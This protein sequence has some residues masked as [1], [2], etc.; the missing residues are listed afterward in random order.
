[1]ANQE[2]FTIV[3]D[4]PAPEAVLV[5]YTTADGTALKYVD[6]V[7]RSGTLTFAAGQTTQTVEVPVLASTTGVTDKAFTLTLSN[8]RPAG[9]A[10]LSA[11][12]ATATCEIS[13]PPTYAAVPFPGY[14]CSLLG[15]SI[16]YMCHHWNPAQRV[17]TDVPEVLRYAFYATGVT[18]WFTYANA[19][20]NQCLELEPALQ[21]NTNPGVNATAPNN[22][23]NF[24]IYSSQIAQWTLADFDPLAAEDPGPLLAHNIGPIVNAQN[25]ISAFDMVMMMGG[26]NDLSGGLPWQGILLNIQ[27]CAYTFAK[28]GKWVF[29]FPITPRSADLLQA[30]NGVG[31]Y[32]QAEVVQIIQNQLSINAG[33]KSWIANDAPPNIFFVDCYEDLVGPTATLIP[34]T[35]T[36]PAGLL[37]P[38]SGIATGSLI[39]SAPGNYRSDAPDSLFNFDGLHPAPPGAYIMGRDLAATM[40]AAGVPVPAGQP[41]TLGPLTI[42]PN[43]MLNPTFA[44]STAPRVIGQPLKL[45]RAIGL[46]API[47]WVSPGFPPGYQG[48]GVDL[49]ANQGHGYTHGAVPDYW[50][51][52]RESNSDGESFSNFNDYTFS[53]FSSP[54]PDAPAGTVPPGYLSDSTWADGAVTTSVVEVD[55]VPGWQ[56]AVNIPA[57]LT[58]NE[59]FTLRYVITEGQHGPWD[60]Y[61]FEQGATA[62]EFPPPY[63]VGAAIAADANI[64][65]SGLT[66]KFQTMRT[67]VNLLSINN[68]EINAGDLSTTGA[69]ISGISCVES[70]FPFSHIADCQ[71]HPE[72]KTLALRTSAVLVPA[73]AAGETIQ[74][75]QL[76]FQFSWDCSTEAATATIVIL[77]PRLARL[78]G[79]AL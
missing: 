79:P 74:Y 23:Y 59:G 46:G 41:T 78:T 38:T 66:G 64:Q 48:S 8:A 17:G 57:G 20:M 22:G 40:V 52:Y 37:S 65:F 24:A 30:V 75:A 32:S 53:N 27:N 51:F 63:A 25:H 1:M 56:I 73:P 4:P 39:P 7:P 19:L 14:R 21:P 3:L 50:F 44:I 28:Q 42:E 60:N 67:V 62:A 58:Q 33:I 6:Y 36:D 15:D 5:D 18:G 35:P 31:G 29:V 9:D 77:Q 70:Y 26:T 45:G 69:I 10:V 71:Q 34:G 43:Y 54:E 49:Y 68:D 47:D 72:N 11:T 61:G 16:T 55:G 12:K 76:D 13:G 2:I